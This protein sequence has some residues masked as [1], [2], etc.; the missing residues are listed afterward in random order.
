MR[1]FIY[2][3]FIIFDSAAHTQQSFYLT[4]DKQFMTGIS[5]TETNI[6]L[7]YCQAFYFG[8]RNNARLRN[9]M[10][11]KVHKTVRT[12]YKLYLTVLIID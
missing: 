10:L 1:E 3:F 8:Q 12:V 4:V 6:M 9:R 11:I 5:G 7:P 2:Q